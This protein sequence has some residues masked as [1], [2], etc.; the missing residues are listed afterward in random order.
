MNDAASTAPRIA[1]VGSAREAILFDPV[2]AAQADAAWLRPAHWGQ[3]QE[4]AD[5]GGRGSVWLVRGDFGEGVLRHFRRGGLVARVNADR[6]LWT[7]EEETRSFREF[8][9]LA[10]LRRRGLPVPAPLVAGY[11][12]DRLSYR[13]DLLTSLIPQAQTL[14]QRLAG[15]FPDTATWRAIGATLARFHAHGAYHADLNA[16]NV[17]LD[18][19][20]AVW[21]IDFDRGELRAPARRWQQDNLIRLQRSLS[22]L[23]ADGDARWSAAWSALDTAWC[24][25]LASEAR[26]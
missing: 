16:H 13:A 20:G 15:A 2:R 5:R 23:G 9:L 12:R 19:E 1:R 10:E 8:R 25:G 21:L 26:A 22:K 17:M 4:A 6:Y 14:A 24:K 3:G 11:R 18:V 7:G